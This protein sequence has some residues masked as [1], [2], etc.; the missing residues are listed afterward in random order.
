MITASVI[1]NVIEKN[2]FGD[3][4]DVIFDKIT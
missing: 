3:K 1:H 2:K 4:D